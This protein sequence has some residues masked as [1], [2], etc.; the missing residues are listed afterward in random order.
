QTWTAAV[1]GGASGL[2]LA[3]EAAMDLDTLTADATQLERLIDVDD[4]TPDGNQRVG[5]LP[6]MPWVTFEVTDRDADGDGGMGDGAITMSDFRRWRDWLYEIEGVGDLDGGS[7]HPKRDPNNNHRHDTMLPSESSMPRGD[8][9]GDGAMSRTATRYV[10]GAISDT[11]TDLEV[12]QAAFDDTHYDAADLDAL[13]DSGDIEVWP[14]VCVMS[15]GPP[16]DHY[17]SSVKRVSDGV[18]VGSRTHTIVDR[19]IYTVEASSDTVGESYQV[20]VRG[21]N[22]L[23][24]TVW[25]DTTTVDVTRGSDTF[26]AP[27]PCPIW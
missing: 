21:V 16:I 24:A 8:F 6:S 19:Q 26:L 25:L 1:D 5:H 9:N 15:G 23:G 20:T 3:F 11:V 2:P 17:T 7:T 27:T 22:T 18:T 10:P 4:G 13:L 14:Q 12:L